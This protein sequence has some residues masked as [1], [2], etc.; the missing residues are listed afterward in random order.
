VERAAAAL[1]AAGA[2]RADWGYDWLPDAWEITRGYWARATGQPGLT[3]ADVH[4]QLRDWDRFRTRC[5]RAMAGVDVLLTPTAAGP[6]PLRSE[7]EGDRA[8]FV[9]TLPASLSGSPALSLPVGAGADGLPLAVQ[10]VGRPWEDHVVLAAARVVE[11]ATAP[12]R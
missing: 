4:R 6:A 9:H 2:R 10:L 12:D 7:P 8:A 5:L 11:R 3:G 1:V